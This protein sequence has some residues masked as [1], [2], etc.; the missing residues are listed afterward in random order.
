MSSDPSAKRLKTD[1]QGASEGSG[2]NFDVC[3]SFEDG[4]TISICGVSNA[5]TIGELRKKIGDTSGRLVAK[6]YD[7]DTGDEVALIDCQ[8][9]GASGL[10]G[11]SRLVGV[12]DSDSKLVVADS[13]GADCTDTDFEALC[14]TAQAVLSNSI[15][16]SRCKLSEQ[17]LSHLAK[18]PALTAL[19]LQNCV[20]GNPQLLAT[21]ILECPAL[22]SLD[23]SANALGASGIGPVVLTLARHK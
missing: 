11:S 16:L 1:T 21:H 22:A 9:A 5:T 10:S 23:L 15:D 20:W 13:L 2:A 18:L 6:L 4:E 8:S 12:V 17:G 3:V 7:L 19:T 14:G